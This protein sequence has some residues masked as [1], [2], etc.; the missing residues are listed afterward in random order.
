M[1]AQT[2]QPRYHSQ[3]EHLKKL[4]IPYSDIFLML[5]SY[6]TMP[7]ETLGSNFRK[8]ASESSEWIEA[9][10]SVV[11]NLE[12]VAKHD[13]CNE[14]RDTGDIEAIMNRFQP[15]IDMMMEL[16]DKIGSVLESPKVA[17]TEEKTD[18][19]EPGT[20]L[21]TLVELQRTTKNIQNDW[22]SL[23]TVLDNVKGIFANAVL[24]RELLTQME[25]VLVE[26][27]DIGFAIDKFQEERSHPST[28][29]STSRSADTP[30]MA[31]GDRTQEKQ[32]NTETLTNVDTRI[33]SLTVMFEALTTQVAAHPS[34]DPKKEELQGQYGMLLELWDDTKARRE[35]ISEELKEDR[36]LAV[37]EQVSG[38]VGSMMESLD[39]A[40]VH[41][42]GLVDQIKGM[43]SENMVLTAPIDRE[44]LYA[45]FKS[46]EAKHKYYAPAVHKMLN[47]LDN[48]IE[49]R[50]T[51]RLD[52]IQKHR[53]MK[54]EWEQ[55][56][57][58][59]DSVELDLDG[60][61]EMLNILDSSMPSH[62]SVT[63]A[64]LPEKPLFAMRRPQ[65]QVEL[66]S[67]PPVLFQPPESSSQVQRG[68]RLLPTSTVLRSSMVSPEP[69]ARTRNR[70][71]VNLQSR[72]RPW[73]PAPSM[74]STAAPRVH[75]R[76]LLQISC[77]HGVQGTLTILITKTTSPNIPGIPYAPSAASMYAPR[78]SSPSRPVS[79]SSIPSRPDSSLRT[80]SISCTASINATSQPKPVFS[81]VGSLSKLSAGAQSARA[82]SPI[83]G[84]S[85]GRRTQLRV[86]PPV[87][88]NNP[89]RPR[90]NSAP[91]T[92]QRRSTSPGPSSHGRGVVSTNLAA[93]LSP[94]QLFSPS[95]SR[96]LALGSQ[97]AR[98]ATSHGYRS[99]HEMD[100]TQQFQDGRRT[101]L[102]NRPNGQQATKAE[103]VS[104]SYSE[105]PET[106]YGLGQS[107]ASGSA[108]SM[109]LEISSG[110]PFEEPT[111]PS[112]S[113][114]SSSGS[115]SRLQHQTQEQQQR[116]QQRLKKS[117]LLDVSE[118]ANIREEPI[119][120]YRPVR[121]DELD[122]EFARILNVSLKQMQVR[123]LGEGKYYFGGRMEERIPG[124]VTAVGGKTVLCRLMEFGRVPAGAEDDSKTLRRPEAVASRSSRPRTR[125]FNNSSSPAPTTPARSR[126]VMVRVG[127]GWQDLDIFLLDLCSR[128]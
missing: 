108:S 28:D 123:R 41:C 33:E 35:R 89:S 69:S 48:G 92:P 102:G 73:S 13:G 99:H 93:Q 7:I 82:P 53:I 85:N 40:I 58:R 38:Q 14:K 65:T 31:K 52:I 3:L 72:E 64:Q 54:N 121:G 21:L 107:A 90:Q 101:S 88:T 81:P 91:E 124:K 95:A 9:A 42:Q 94:R 109:G 120:S 11:L 71:P 127:G 97:N 43:V 19:D 86:P 59:L 6:D 37:F 27:E 84:F 78:P 96:Q 39:R 22:T 26:V 1:A 67:A 45:I 125:S 20:S 114:S 25:D 77:A 103:S 116:Q 126:K 68:R 55:L 30:S 56:R 83:P 10:K 106:I 100:N 32:R 79:P 24:R 8:A 118:K 119:A 4:P 5:T 34:N 51:K 2:P 66:R 111:S 23:K 117:E 105:G 61:E 16:R 63:P 112:T 80:R 50:T 75:H 47:M 29:T 115:F 70:S 46:F 98:S 74:T 44:H 17:G 62:V 36:W 60:I 104:G 57:T 15:I 12:M 113:S 49:S 122:E 18:G 128:S 76:E 87:D 110:T